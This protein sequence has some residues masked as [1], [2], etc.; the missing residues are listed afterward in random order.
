MNENYKKLVDLIFPYASNQEARIR[1]ENKKFCHY[2]SAD[3]AIKIIKNK[4]VWLRHYSFMNDYMEVDHGLDCLIHAYSEESTFI[5]ALNDIQP[6]LSGEVEKIFNEV[7]KGLKQNLYL[8]SVSEHEVEEDSIG[9]LSM[10]RAYGK[11]SGVALI[12]NNEAF[13]STAQVLNTWATPVIYADKLAFQNELKK[14][15]EGFLKEKDFL[16]K[17]PLNELAIKITNAFLFSVIS[18]KH[19]GFKEEKE[20]RVVFFSDSGSEY[21]KEEIVTILGVPQRVYKI[22]LKNI[23]DRGLTGL[24]L[25]ELI[26]RIIIGPTSQPIHMRDLF[27]SEL[28]KAGVV[29]AEEKVFVSDIPLRKE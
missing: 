10:W 17:I 5:K 13:Q 1:N 22:P 4:E 20:W 27:I 23:P 18:T 15:A 3:A 9:R 14:L 16:K 25:N 28:Q 8:L 6:S 21:V 29:N 24:C 2:T 11:D 12:L 7:I 19:L 26:D